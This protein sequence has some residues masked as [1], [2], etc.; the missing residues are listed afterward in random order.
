M[1]FLAALLPEALAGGEAAAAGTAAAETGSGGGIMS[2]FENM[3]GMGGQGKGIAKEEITS[4]EAKRSAESMEREGVMGMNSKP[5]PKTLPHNTEGLEIPDGKG[6]GFGSK[7]MGFAE[8][9]GPGVISQAVGGVAM[10][11][12]MLLMG[13]MG[14]G[15]VSGMEAASMGYGQVATRGNVPRDSYE[16]VMQQHGI[17][18]VRNQTMKG[19]FDMS[20]Y[21]DMAMDHIKRQTYQLVDP[22]TAY[23][24]AKRY[25]R[26]ILTNNAS[27]VDVRKNAAWNLTQY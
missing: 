26:D 22:S 15:G 4:M 7:V 13:G 3:L 18:S 5:G 2:M 25:T 17:G 19:V 24:T 8:K 9:H 23:N 6:K 1:A 11:A 27:D 16:G 21:S 14:G 12:P 10:A 20:G